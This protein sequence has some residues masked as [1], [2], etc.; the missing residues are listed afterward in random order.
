[1]GSTRANGSKIVEH[2]A[3]LFAGSIVASVLNY[4]FNPLLSRLLSVAEFGEVQALSALAVQLMVFFTVIQVLVVN[5][6][7]NED[8]SD[9][10][11]N[12]IEALESALLRVGFAVAVLVVA[13]SGVIS[14]ALQLESRLPILFLAP[15]IAVGGIRTSRAGLLQAEQDFVGYSI[16]EIMG[17]ASRLVLAAS[18]AA[19]GFGSTGAT[20]GLVLATPLAALTA[21]SLCRRDGL[22]R[23]STRRL[24]V[25]V[26]GLAALR[27]HAR[28]A[29][30]SGWVALI[31]SVLVNGD[32]IVA[33]FAFSPEDAGLYTG[34]AVIGRILFFL[35][36][37]VAAVLISS[38]KLSATPAANVRALGQSAV[39]LIIPAL[40]VLG[41]FVFNPDVTIRFL[42][43]AEYIAYAD[44]LPVLGAAMMA[45]S[46]VN[47]ILVYHVALRD[48]GA[49]VAATI[50]ISLTAAV[51]A[52]H[53]EDPS[54]L[55]RSVLIGAGLTLLL[56]VSW[57]VRWNLLRSAE[58]TV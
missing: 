32:S 55:A 29:L 50:G 10:R 34:V 21:T 4:A 51:I 25:G 30:L 23:S 13:F 54:A 8:R 2:N 16:V 45:I 53:H 9:A 37:S 58:P 47:L 22:L 39:L 12:F 20:A 5:V 24:R 14:E 7:S 44:L 33:K 43:G 17:S 35:T 28:F 38:V 36:A 41:V 48:N 52:V 42:V 15:L 46:L 26:D 56:C 49:A 18:L 6:I 3:L 27:P 1:M 31:I 57:T 11:Q 40:L 19:F